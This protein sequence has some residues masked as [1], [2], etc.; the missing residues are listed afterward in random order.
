MTNHMGVALGTLPRCV[1]KFLEDKCRE[2]GLD[3]VR[4][5]EPAE[6]RTDYGAGRPV[7]LLARKP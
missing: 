2:A 1:R 5:E 3:V 6:A 7:R 4:Y